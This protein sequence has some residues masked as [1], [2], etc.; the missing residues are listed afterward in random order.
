VKNKILVTFLLFLLI[1]LVLPYSIDRKSS[2]ADALIEV[3][4]MLSP[5]TI[6]KPEN[7]YMSTILSRNTK[8][9]G[10]K[11]NLTLQRY[12][13]QPTIKWAIRAEKKHILN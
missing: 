7:D 9:L 1:S 11:E 10:L 6:P 5:Q 4:L 12:L 8:P 3:K 13:D 2:Y